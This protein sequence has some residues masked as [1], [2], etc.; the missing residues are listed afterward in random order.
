MGTAFKINKRN[1]ISKDCVSLENQTKFR[2]L[3]PGQIS[4]FV[5]S[6]LY[7]NLALVS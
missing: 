1:V 3:H 7:R 4:C 6:N 2:F 5:S